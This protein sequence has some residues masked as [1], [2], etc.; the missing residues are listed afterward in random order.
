MGRF[1]DFVLKGKMPFLILICF[2]MIYHVLKTKLIGN[3]LIGA[4]EG[5]N[6][7]SRSR[8]NESISW[9]NC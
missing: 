2:N 1:N 9:Q 3:S 4:K 5:D 7:V 6:G 8:I